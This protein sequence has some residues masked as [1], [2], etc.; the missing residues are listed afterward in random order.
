VTAWEE[1]L[2]IT[3]EEEEERGLAGPTAEVWNNNKQVWS[4]FI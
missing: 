1:V 2:T 3:W 4:T